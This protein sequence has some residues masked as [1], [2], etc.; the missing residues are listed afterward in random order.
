MD[1]ATVG[2]AVAAAWLAALAALIAPC[3]IARRADQL[4]EHIHV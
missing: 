1:P 2:I 4:L 3:K